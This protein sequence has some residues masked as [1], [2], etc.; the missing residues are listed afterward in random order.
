LSTQTDLTSTTSTTSTPTE[1]SERFCKK[2]TCS[3]KLERRPGE[4]RTHFLSR[5]HCGEA[6]SKSNPDLHRAQS[7]RFKKIRESETRICEICNG[8]YCRS[9]HESR[10]VFHT[11]ATC[12]RKCCDIKRVKDAEEERKKEP[13]KICENPDCGKEFHRHRY[14]NGLMEGKKRFEKRR[15]CSKEC[16]TV[17]RL[18][19]NQ[20]TKKGSGGGKPPRKTPVVKKK[21]EDKQEFEE[22]STLPPTEEC[23]IPIPEPP[24][25]EFV[26]IWRPAVWGGSY[27]QKVG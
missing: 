11:R 1:S 15:T 14:A 9:E 26:E 22:E 18:K 12:S 20:G 3:K 21:R 7:D 4:P 27:T 5:V 25:P 2:K 13:G 10:S 23:P 19:N 8:S 17:I 16:G 24:K 6:C